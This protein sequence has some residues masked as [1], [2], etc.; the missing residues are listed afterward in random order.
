MGGSAPVPPTAGAPPGCGYALSAS[1]PSLLLPSIR[2]S[3]ADDE[4]FSPP[5]FST[6]PCRSAT[7]AKASVGGQ[8][9][10]AE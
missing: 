2:P 10:H 5:S 1:A 7:A 8:A 3:V 6:A 9:H 4:R